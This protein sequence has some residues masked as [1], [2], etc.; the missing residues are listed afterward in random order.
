VV[1]LFF[2]SRQ[3]TKENGSRYVQKTKED[4]VFH[5]P[6]IVIKTQI[7]RLPCSRD[8][9]GMNY[10]AG[11][12]IPVI[13]IHPISP[14]TNNAQPIYPTKDNM[15]R[16]KNQVYNCCIVFIEKFLMAICISILHIMCTMR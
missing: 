13:L 14:F 1:L 16:K 6:C 5:Q 11:N 8:L 2:F 3:K 9:F 15:K 4:G 12:S 7:Q 10:V